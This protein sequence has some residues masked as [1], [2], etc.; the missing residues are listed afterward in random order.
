LL[1]L[2]IFNSGGYWALVTGT[3]WGYAG[4]MR[5]PAPGGLTAAERA[6]RERVR[7][8]AAEMIEAGGQRPG[9][10]EAVRGIADERE[11]A[12]AD[13]GRRRPGCGQVVYESG[14]LAIQVPAEVLEQ[15]KRHAPL[16]RRAVRVVNPVGRADHFVRKA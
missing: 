14:I 4:V 7:L 6:R 10:R 1:L 13:P 5:Y 9:D 3:R 12:A 8:V 16:A 11:P 2:A 15:D